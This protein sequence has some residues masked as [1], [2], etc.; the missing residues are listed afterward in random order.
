MFW[1]DWPYWPKLVVLLVILG[2]YLW[3]SSVLRDFLPLGGFFL[4]RIIAWVLFGL[5]LGITIGKIRSRKQG[6]I[7]A[8]NQANA[9]EEPKEG[10]MGRGFGFSFIIALFCAILGAIFEATTGL[11]T[12]TLGP[13]M[14]FILLN[15]Y[16]L[17]K[18]KNKKKKGGMGLGYLLLPA[19]V[20]GSFI[21]FFLWFML[22][23]GNT[24]FGFGRDALGF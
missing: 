22:F 6:K 16:F 20:I 13:D 23:K 2:G 10:D 24:W 12:I 7:Y 5:I 4:N 8:E 3:S 18:E 14:A 17:L 11:V 21:V 9:F 15:G 19:V 1:K